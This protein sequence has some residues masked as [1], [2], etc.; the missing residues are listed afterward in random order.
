MAGNMSPIDRRVV[1]D[2]LGGFHHERRGK[3][4]HGGEIA[5]LAIDRFHII[6]HTE[7][8]GRLV[9]V[10]APVSICWRITPPRFRRSSFR[11]PTPTGP[12]LGGHN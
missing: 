5:L 6:L 1:T 10:A 8:L 7:E 12:R 4:A 11:Q 2:I 3:D 9:L